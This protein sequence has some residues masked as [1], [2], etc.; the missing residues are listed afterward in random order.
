MAVEGAVAESA[1][2][3]NASVR[4]LAGTGDPLAVATNLA[5]AIVTE[6]GASGLEGPPFDPFALAELLGLSLRARVDVADARISADTVGVRSAPHAPLGHF[7]G[8]TRPLAI[9]YNPTRPR[10]RLRYSV[11]HEIAHGL[12]PDV[13]D[14][15][16]HRT[17]AGAVPGY[18]GGDSWQL[19]LLCNVIAAELL[20]P[21]QAVAGLVDIDPDIDFIMEQRRR[22]DVSTEAL[23]RRL[24]AKTA[25]SIALI[26]ASRLRDAVDSPLTVEYVVGSANF[27]PSVRRRAVVPTASVLGECVAVGQ[28]TRGL[29]TIESV[30]L[31]VQAVGVPPYPGNSLP[32]VLALVEPDTPLHDETGALHYR[33][34]DV[35][36]IALGDTPLVIAHVVT[37]SARVWSRRGVA[38]ALATRFPGAARAFQAWA[39]ATPASLDLGNVHIADAEV[40]RRPVTIV[41]MVAQRGYGPGFSTRLDYQ[42]LDSAL[43]SV[44]EIALAKGAEVYLPRIGAGQAGGRWDLIA[45]AIERTLVHAGLEVAVYTLPQRPRG[46]SRG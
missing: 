9:E 12:F 36:D 40:H 5:K 14:T 31:R 24:V 26:A 20:M 6:A 27:A 19:E 44:T 17:G 23:L 16:R 22:F 15:V 45:Q 25:R 21:D 7:V 18:G 33:S 29:E 46:D 11:A 39:V 38:A 34:G 43:K 35:T 42:A 3:T 28:T 32:R 2:W 41:S 1:S 13:A 10:G 30:P 37:D 8:A 4:L